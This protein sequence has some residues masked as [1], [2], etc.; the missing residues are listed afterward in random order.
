MNILVFGGSGKIGSAIAW[1]LV[2]EEDVEAVGIIGRRRDALEKTKAWISNPKV[3]SYNLDIADT[4]TI[5]GLMESYDVGVIALPDRRTSY[6]VLEMAIDANLNI[7]DI[8]EEYHRRSDPYETEGLDIPN[9]MIAA[10]YGEWLH[11]KG[12]A[13]SLTSDEALFTC[14]SY[15]DTFFQTSQLLSFCMLI[16]TAIQWR[17]TL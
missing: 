4:Q 12:Q 7:V 2:K 11:E 13:R 6:Q 10:D 16:D 14:V 3:K 5:M 17:T 15:P 8:L 9:G 1:D